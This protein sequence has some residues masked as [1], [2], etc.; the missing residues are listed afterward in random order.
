ME[1]NYLKQALA[2]T[3]TEG[4][5]SEM[6]LK[7]EED[8]ENKEKSIKGSI[9]VKTGDINFTKYEINSKEFTKKGDH[10]PS[11]QNLLGFMDRA[12]SIAEVGEEEATCVSIRSGQ[13]QPYTSF[14]DRGV[15]FHKISYKTGFINIINKEKC[16]PKSIFKLECF[17]KDMD[18]ELDS[19]EIPT[20]RLILHALVP[21]YNNGIES[22]DIVVPQEYAQAAERLFSTPGRESAFIMGKIENSVQLRKNEIEFEIGGSVTEYSEDKNNELVLTNAKTMDDPYELET[23]QRAVAE[24]D[25]VL[26]D[27]KKKR[28][29]NASN[30]KSTN[31]AAGTQRRNFGF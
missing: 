15:A 1:Q 18:D 20:G 4:I 7:I 9:T 8:G 19:Q 30:N 2:R 26:E 22:L 29:E 11:Y 24:Y 16:N 23:I 28:M 10:N 25:L 6:D 17:I 27:R 13:L 21:I 3:E 14:N 12:H 31:S 5:L